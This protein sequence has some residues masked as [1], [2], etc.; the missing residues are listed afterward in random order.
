MVSNVYK[1]VYIQN[2][3]ISYFVLYS[4]IGIRLQ[5]VSSKTLTGHSSSIFQAIFL[6]DNRL[7]SCSD[8]ETIKVWD[9]A[10]GKEQFTLRAHTGIFYSIAILPNGWLRRSE[11]GTWKKGRK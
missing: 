1:D 5:E 9:T 4:Y 6:S 7:V 2:E 3:I 10:S 11:Y 8:D